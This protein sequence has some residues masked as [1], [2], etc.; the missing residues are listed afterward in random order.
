MQVRWALFAYCGALASASH[1]S[2]VQ[3]RTERKGLQE[4]RVLA[5]AL[6]SNIVFLNLVRMHLVRMQNSYT[7][8]NMYTENACA[9]VTVQA[10]VGQSRHHG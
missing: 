10:M 3:N 5:N 1:C 9:K 4:H 6:I 8:V 7:A 2:T